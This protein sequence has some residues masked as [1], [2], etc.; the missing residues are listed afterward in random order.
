MVLFWY[1]SVLAVTPSCSPPPRPENRRQIQKVT[2]GLPAG[3][4]QGLPGNTKNP[5]KNLLDFFAIFYITFLHFGSQLG[6]EFRGFSHI[7]RIDFCID[8][9]GAI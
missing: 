5:L 4:F 1:G 9:R 7:C 2:L 6:S 3:R 8:F